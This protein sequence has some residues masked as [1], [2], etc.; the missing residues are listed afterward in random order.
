MVSKLFII[1][2]TR[3][4]IHWCILEYLLQFLHNVDIHLSFYRFCFPLFHGQRRSSIGNSLSCVKFLKFFQYLSQ[5]YNMT[6][7]W[8]IKF[9]RPQLSE[10]FFH[11]L[12]FDVCVWCHTFSFKILFHFSLYCCFSYF[13]F[14]CCLFRIDW[15]MFL[16]VILTLRNK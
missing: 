1:Y 9:I 4:F 8:K 12:I 10:C 15:N 13:Q 7:C 2:Y 5:I 11:L 6:F 14:C 16:D 3:Y